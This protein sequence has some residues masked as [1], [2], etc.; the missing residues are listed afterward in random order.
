VWVW[1]RLKLRC[2]EV[3]GESVRVKEERDGILVSGIYHS[4]LINADLLHN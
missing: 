2:E 1:C 3:E 4:L